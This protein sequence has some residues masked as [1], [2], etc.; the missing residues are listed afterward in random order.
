M[1]ED[2]IQPD[3][4][5]NTEMDFLKGVIQLALDKGNLAINRS[6]NVRRGLFARHN[7]LD[8]RITLLEDKNDVLV[9]E[10]D[11][12]KKS[13]AQMQDEIHTVKETIFGNTLKLHTR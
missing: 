11:L 2:Y 8:K 3:M 4:F 10:N 13:I 7:D 6:D 5:K 1:E 9:L 12:L